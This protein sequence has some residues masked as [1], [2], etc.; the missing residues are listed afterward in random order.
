MAA[1]SETYL[2]FIRNMA[3]S[4]EFTAPFSAL[5]NNHENVLAKA[6]HEYS[7]PRFQV[8]TAY[9]ASELENILENLNR[10]GVLPSKVQ[11]K[12]VKKSPQPQVTVHTTHPQEKKPFQAA[13][14][15]KNPLQELIKE[16][17]TEKQ[18]AV[19]APQTTKTATPQS[20]VSVISQLKALRLAQQQKTV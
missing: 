2:V 10:W 11:H 13:E 4:E 7:E 12:S 17:K 20:G 5:K 8:H 16:M 19:P 6:R 1:Q 9:T 15:G 3:T 18:P 14:N